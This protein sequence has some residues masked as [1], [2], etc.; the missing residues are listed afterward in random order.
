MSA[1]ECRVKSPTATEPS[2]C[3][4]GAAHSVRLS[5][6]DYSHGRRHRSARCSSAAVCSLSPIS[7]SPG[8]SHD[9]SVAA[10]ALRLLVKLNHPATGHPLIETPGQCCQPI[11]P[12]WPSC[13][14]NA[15][16]T[17]VR[18]DVPPPVVL[19][20]SFTSR[21]SEHSVSIGALRVGRVT[22]SSCA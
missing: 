2:T 18:A 1:I 9:P 7:A 17:L 5:N 14:A 15:L 20:I 22:I 16:I 21:T 13:A 3:R 12:Y 10:A 4:D 11:L 6:Y 8:H 19:I